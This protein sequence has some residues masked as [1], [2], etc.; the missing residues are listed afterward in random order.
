MSGVVFAVRPRQNTR[1]S[2]AAATSGTTECATISARL[3]TASLAKIRLRWVDTVHTLISNELAI[4]WLVRPHATIL[5]TCCSR[6]LKATTRVGWHSSR[7]QRTVPRTTSK[8]MPSST[9]RRN[10]PKP[11]SA[12]TSSDR[13]LQSL[14]ADGF[15]GFFGRIRETSIICRVRVVIGGFAIRVQQRHSAQLRFTSY[16]WSPLDPQF[17]AAVIDEL[18]TTA[19]GRVTECWAVMARQR[20]EKHHRSIDSPCPIADSEVLVRSVRSVIDRSQP[21]QDRRLE[22]SVH[23]NSD[24]GNRSSRGRLNRRCAKCSST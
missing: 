14:L 16:H 13:S 24:C 23:E 17:L 20:I 5:A 12:A 7:R 18:S 19:A 22:K 21:E 3:E 2:M 15:T 1:P 8:R 10:L 4:A 6:G 9:S 11:T